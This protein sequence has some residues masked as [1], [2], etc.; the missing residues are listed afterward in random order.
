[1][2]NEN[3][4]NIS[5]TRTAP[6]EACSR[7]VCLQAE[8]P[9]RSIQVVSNIDDEA[10]GPSYAVVRL[11]RELLA[12]GESLRLVTLRGRQEHSDIPFLE[13]YPARSAL[14]RLGFSPLMRDRLIHAAEDCD[15]IH[16]NSLWMM[17]NVY[18]GWAV[19][20]RQCQLVISPQGTLSNWA[21]NHSGWKK[22]VFWTLVQGRAVSHASCFHA[23]AESEYQDIRSMGLRRR[24]V[25]I[26]PNGVD[27]PEMR[28]KPTTRHRILLF[29]GRVHPVKGVDLLLLAWSAVWHRFPEWELRIIGPDSEGYLSK[30]TS[31][32][33]E[34]RLRRAV[35]CGPKYGQTKY[36]AYREA[37]LF[38]LPT[39]SENFGISVAES[40]ATGTPAIVTKRAPWCG[41]EEHRAG[42]WVDFGV[43]PLVGALE[44]AMS[45]SEGELA[46]M[47]QRG[48]E[49]MTKDY[50]WPRI[51]R[52]MDKTY[53]WLLFGGETPAWVKLD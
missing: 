40:L 34:L 30:M 20:G 44:Y 16:N 28:P 45:R 42:W 47:G 52:M 32:A 11:C 12:C 22:R 51:G 43:D 41:L 24:P 23:T 25:C 18:P 6:P 35:F 17:P 5:V 38:V 1:M 31:M 49:W 26:I 29:L 48:R 36:A 3:Q 15:I 50:A 33:R 27:V 7:E 9:I 10:G 39:R 8:R 2:D 37:E 46:K 53:R 19:R 4:S 21:L 13:M 14:G